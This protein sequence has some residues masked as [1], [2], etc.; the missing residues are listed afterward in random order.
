MAGPGLQ[1]GW[2]AQL[3]APFLLLLLLFLLLLL[4]PQLLLLS[5]PKPLLALLQTLLN[6]VRGR[7]PSVCAC[8]G[9]AACRWSGSAGKPHTGWSASE[10]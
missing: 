7:L 2:D 10:R 4:L 5:Q 8:A 3:R 9:W 1:L 6:V